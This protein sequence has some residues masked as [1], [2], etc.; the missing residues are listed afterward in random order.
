[1]VSFFKLTCGQVKN[2][3][4]AEKKIENLLVQAANPE[5]EMLQPEH[6]ARQE[7]KKLEPSSVARCRLLVP[8]VEI[9]KATRTYVR[10]STQF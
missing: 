5:S 3:S 1:M 6:R 9:L 4:K 2:H 7:L 10:D 8:L